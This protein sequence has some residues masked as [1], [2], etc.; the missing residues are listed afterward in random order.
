[1]FIHH[2]PK[3]NLFS[4]YLWKNT[5]GMVVLKIF[6][7]KFCM[8]V[9]SCYTS[10][11]ILLDLL[12]RKNFFFLCKRV[13]SPKCSLLILFFSD[14]KRKKKKDDLLPYKWDAKLPLLMYTYTSIC[15]PFSAQYPTKFTRFLWCN[16]PNNMT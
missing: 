7:T 3:T 2:I 8:Y 6:W 15:C 1:M 12:G 11:N 9:I 10:L 16:L 13:R 5:N 14:K 4:S